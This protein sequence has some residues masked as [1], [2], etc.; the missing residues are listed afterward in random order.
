MGLVNAVAQN[1][2]EVVYL[3]NGSIIRGIIIEQIPNE[4]L[5]I[6]TSDG[7]VFA[8]PMQDV[9]KITKERPLVSVNSAEYE[10]VK[11]PKKSLENQFAA[12]SGYTGFV[13]IGG[14]LG[15]DL[16]GAF[17]NITTSHGYQIIP[18]LFT[19]VGVGAHFD[20]DNTL[21]SIPAFA[22]IRYNILNNNI[23][24]F[25]GV[26]VGYAFLD[27]QGVY[28]S[29]SLGCR[30]GLSK[31]IALNISFNYQLQG[32]KGSYSYSSYYYET[33]IKLHYL[34]FRVGVEF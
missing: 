29:P 11:T 32:A 18:Q 9:L 17:V 27:M 1:L 28:F 34:G 23:T 30:F 5:K 10:N 24:P 13:D 26:K 2:T 21:F 20:I 19:G 15:L 14:G 22:D 31:N 8:Y 16:A 7:S 12:K 4:S 25:L 3:K 6:Q 33:T